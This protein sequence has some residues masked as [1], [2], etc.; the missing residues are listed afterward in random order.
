MNMRESIIELYRGKNEEELDEDGAK[1]Q[2]ATN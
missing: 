2:Y 1:R